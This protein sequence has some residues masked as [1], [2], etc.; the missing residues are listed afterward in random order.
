MNCRGCLPA[1]VATLLV[2]LLTL[3]VFTIT[4]GH[5]LTAVD[6]FSQAD[7]IVVLGGGGGNFFRVQQAVD[8]IQRRLRSSSGLQRRHN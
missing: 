6:A 3:G 2:G 4:V 1:G 8:L 7:A 5:F